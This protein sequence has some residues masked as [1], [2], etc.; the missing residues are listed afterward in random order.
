MEGWR[1]RTARNRKEHP[2]DGVG[3]PPPMAPCVELGRRVLGEQGT[4]ERPYPARVV[5]GHGVASPSVIANPPGPFTILRDFAT[6]DRMPPVTQIL[7]KGSQYLL[8]PRRW[9]SV[10]V[11]FELP[12]PNGKLIARFARNQQFQCRHAVPGLA[13]REDLG[14]V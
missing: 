4:V 11:G 7:E 1:G 10:M 6:R 8:S 13:N 3:Q 5:E 12:R 9:F 14:G 2:V